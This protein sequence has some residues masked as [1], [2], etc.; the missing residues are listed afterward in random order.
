MKIENL[1]ILRPEPQYIKLDGKEVDVS[2]IPC[3]ITF[4]IDAI[5]NSLT[6]ITEADLLLG[7]EKTK[8]ALG[9]SIDLC[10]TFCSIQY[11]EM[12]REWFARNVDA[13]QIKGFV[14][15]IRVALI[16]AYAGASEGTSPK[17]RKAAKNR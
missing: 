2:F 3:G 14:E 11:P 7:G 10:S 17:N 16:K 8:Q 1:D 4:E 9:L 6:T 5:M 12:N 15:A 13:L